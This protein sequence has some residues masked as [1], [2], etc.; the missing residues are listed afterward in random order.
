MSEENVVQKGSFDAA[1]SANEMVLSQ[2]MIS[3]LRVAMPQK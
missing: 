1:W 3:G 2:A